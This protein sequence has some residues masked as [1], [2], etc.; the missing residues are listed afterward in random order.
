MKYW[1]GSHQKKVTK[2]DDNHIKVEM[3][4][5][6]I[7]SIAHT[8]VHNSMKICDFWGSLPVWECGLKSV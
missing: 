2:Y 5:M 7:V 3:S 8:K 1:E 4:D 6:G